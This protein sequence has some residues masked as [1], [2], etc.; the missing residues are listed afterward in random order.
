M[1]VKTPG[2]MNE[3]DAEDISL[4]P[5]PFCG[6]DIAMFTKCQEMK[7]CPD[8]RSCPEGHYICA[9][10]SFQRGGCGASTGF[11]PTPKEAADAWNERA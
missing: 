10:C 11:F 1:C 6:K 7:F 2:P 8:Y 3:T 9:V 4:S 5:C